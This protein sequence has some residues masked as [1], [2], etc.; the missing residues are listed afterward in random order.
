MELDSV[1]PPA[2]RIH[3]EVLFHEARYEGCAFTIAADQQQAVKAILDGLVRD[4]ILEPVGGRRPHWSL[5]VVDQP[6][7]QASQCPIWPDKCKECGEA[8]AF[9]HR[10]ECSRGH[11][12]QYPNIVDA[13]RSERRRAVT[14]AFLT[15]TTALSDSERHDALALFASSFAVLSC[16]TEVMLSVLWEVTKFPNYHDMVARRHRP[17]DGLS[18]DLPR[19]IYDESVFPGYKDE[20]RFAALTLDGRGVRRFGP[21]VAKLREDVLRQTA[22][23][24]VENSFFARENAKSP[25]DPLLA[26][27]ASWLHRDLLAVA[28]V[29]KSLGKPLRR[30]EVEPKLIVDGPTARDDEFVEVHVFGPIG[31]EAIAEVSVPRSERKLEDL[32]EAC[33]RNRIKFHERA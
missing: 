5:N 21:C 16:D 10:K 30:R 6:C 25:L 14:D 26:A 9:V 13:C 22:S 31:A 7:F 1:D 4:R 20:I 11:A 12:L 32:R 15:S 3:V 33:Q 27:K 18:W 8:I 28:K 19:T 23:V 2:Q 17:P 29:A 24:F